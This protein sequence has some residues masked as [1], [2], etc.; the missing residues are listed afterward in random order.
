VATVQTVPQLP[1]ADELSDAWAKLADVEE[2]TLKPIMRSVFEALNFEGEQKITFEQIGRL[3]AW[4]SEIE[5]MAKR[6]AEQAGKVQEAALSDLP[7]IATEGS[8][9]H[10]PRFDRWGTRM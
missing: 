3:G 10:E 8:N 6:I 9:P 1:T 4:A 2:D 5:P 7:P